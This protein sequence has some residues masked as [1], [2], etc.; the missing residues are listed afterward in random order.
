MDKDKPSHDQINI[1]IDKKHLTSPNPTNGNAL[2]AL[3]EIGE[4]Y[5]L[6]RE[7]HGQGDDEF[8]ARSEAEVSL[9]N[10]DHF[11]SAQSSLNPGCT[12][13]NR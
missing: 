7:V 13:G 12:D 3:G 5:D 2:Y 6:F 4:G 9:H 11:Y 10:G 1:V 8:I